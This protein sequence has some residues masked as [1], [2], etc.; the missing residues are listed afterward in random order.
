MLIWV[1]LMGAGVVGGFVLIAAAGDQIAL[2]VVVAIGG[3]SVAA[4]FLAAGALVRP[5][6]VNGLARTSNRPVHL[7]G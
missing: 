5:G 7:E 3:V 4:S 2:P 1:A 6:S